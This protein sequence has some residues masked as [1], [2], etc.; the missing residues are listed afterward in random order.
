[1]V[2]VLKNALMF[3]SGEAAAGTS[4]E[5]KLDRGADD[6]HA[7]GVQNLLELVVINLI[8]NAFQAMP[9]GG[10]LT[11][12]L[13]AMAQKS[14]SRSAT[15]VRE[16]QMLMSPRYSIRSSRVGQT[17]DDRGSVCPSLIPSCANT[18]DK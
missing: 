18:A 16:Y 14:S 13:R 8:L 17:A 9:D 7:E 10:R 2:D 1:M 5:W 3:A 11:I 15:P 12:G 6:L 4:V